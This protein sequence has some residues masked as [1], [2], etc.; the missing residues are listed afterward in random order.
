MSEQEN[1]EASQEVCTAFRR[2]GIPCDARGE[3]RTPASGLGGRPARPETQGHE[4][5]RALRT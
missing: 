4:V 1:V 5:R 3:G 2:G